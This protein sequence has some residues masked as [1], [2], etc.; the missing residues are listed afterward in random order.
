M[1]ACS[2][3]RFFFFKKKN[4]DHPIGTCSMMP[5][6]QAGVVD[7]QLKVYGTENLR[8]VDAR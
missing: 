6:K 8:V 5:K 2:I 3:K 7:A 1:F 4:V